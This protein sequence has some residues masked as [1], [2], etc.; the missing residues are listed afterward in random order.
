M[1]STPHPLPLTAVCEYTAEQGV[2]GYIVNMPD[3]PQIAG[4]GVMEVKKQVENQVAQY[5]RA[6]NRTKKYSVTFIIL[7]PPSAPPTQQL[8]QGT[9]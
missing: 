4:Q 2:V 7:Y 6:T 8:I 9:V 1:V 3:I 5:N